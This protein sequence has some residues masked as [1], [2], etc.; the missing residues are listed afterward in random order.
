MAKA[1]GCQVERFMSWVEFPQSGCWEWGSTKI[2]SG[3]A[4]FKVGGRN[5]FGHRWI[6]ERLVSKVPSGLELD[7]R[8]R[9]RGCVNPW[10]LEVVTRTEQMLRTRKTHCWHGHPLSGD[11]LYVT[12]KHG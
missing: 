4:Q 6:F 5:H 10:H 12:P 9:N 1:A 3:Y 7:H 2:Y 8:C 11:N